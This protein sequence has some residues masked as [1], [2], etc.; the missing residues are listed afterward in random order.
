VA[1]DPIALGLVVLYHA[2]IGDGDFDLAQ[3]GDPGQ[4]D[5]L[6][7]SPKE[8]LKDL[9]AAVDMNARRDRYGANL[10]YVLAV[11]CSKIGVPD[12]DSHKQDLGRKIVERFDAEDPAAAEMSLDNA[13]SRLVDFPQLTSDVADSFVEAFGTSVTYTE[14]AESVH[15]G[16]SAAETVAMLTDMSCMDLELSMNSTPGSVTVGGRKIEVFKFDHEFCTPL[17]WERLKVAVDPRR[18]PVYNPGFF[19]SVQVLS[20]ATVGA[21]PGWTGVI[22]ESVG[23]MPTTGT[24]AVTNLTVTYHET[25]DVAITAYELGPD[26]PGHA[27]DGRVTIDYGFF[28]VVDEGH[29]RRMRM[30][31]VLHIDGFETWPKWIWWLWAQQISLSGYLFEEPGP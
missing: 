29:H 11:R 17:S 6:S 16:G 4:V 10:A 5:D 24:P 27:D 30:V 22:Q 12:L 9:V 1:D 14:L 15:F 31:K 25:T 18:W 28:G 20:S 2:L 3:L 7:V 21:G 19:H 23:V 8:A 13:V 26:V